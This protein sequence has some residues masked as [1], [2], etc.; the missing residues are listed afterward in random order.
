MS[1][2]EIE[3]LLAARGCSIVEDG[4]RFALVYP[5]GYSQR[6]KAHDLAATDRASANAEAWVWL[7]PENTGT[8]A[9]FAV[10]RVVAEDFGFES[11]ALLEKDRTEPLASARRIAMTLARELSGASYSYIGEAFARDHGTI[12]SAQQSVQ[13]QCDTDAAFDARVGTLRAACQ[14]ALKP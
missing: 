11:K 1:A 6:H 5:H 8:A 2:D 13:D 4:G 10:Q 3:M 14:A 7:H 12:I 9:V